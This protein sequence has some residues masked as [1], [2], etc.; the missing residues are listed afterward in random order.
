MGSGAFVTTGGVW[1]NASSRAYKKDI[2]PLQID[3]AVETLKN[4]QP[5]TFKYKTDNE[6]RVGFIA[7]DVPDIVASKDRKGLSAMDIVAVLT[8]VV[9]DQ[10]AR[11][12]ILTFPQTS[13]TGHPQAS[14]RRIRL[15]V[16]SIAGTPG[17]SMSVAAR[18]RPIGAETHLSLRVPRGRSAGCH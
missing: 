2:A 15:Q 14:R 1:T 7:E 16:P 13:S 17:F 6:K 5:V 11:M 12:G 10:Q 18:S 3:T 4:L 9:Q 8:K